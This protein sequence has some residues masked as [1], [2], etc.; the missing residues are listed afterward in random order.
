MLYLCYVLA[1]EVG[2]PPL[3]NIIKIIIMNNN[4][5]LND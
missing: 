1:Y 2:K 4:N 5:P 3:L